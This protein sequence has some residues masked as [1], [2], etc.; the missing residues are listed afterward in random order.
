ML[1][2]Y[3]A[4]L[5]WREHVHDVLDQ[6][7]Y[8][9][10]LHTI[11][12]S[13]IVGLIALNIV[14]LVIETVEPIGRS[15]SQPFRWIEVASVGIFSV[16]YLLRLWCCTL[17][18]EYAKPVRGRLRY[19]ATPMAVIDLLAVLPF[20]L[21]F[22]GADLRHW[23]VLRLFRIFRIA[24]LSRYSESLRTF[25]R[26]LVAKKEDLISSLLVAS[27]LF[28]LAASTLYAVENEA[29]PERFASIPDAMWWAIATLSTVG[30][31]D[32]FPV[33]PLGKLMAG[34]IAILSVG[35]FALPTG[36]LGAAFVEEMS[37]KKQATLV[38][39][40]CGCSLAASGVEKPRTTEAAARMVVWA[41]DEPMADFLVL[42]LVGGCSGYGLEY[43]WAGG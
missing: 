4:S 7:Q 20:Y 39:P 25:G 26:V 5:T 6:G 13:S 37:K 36:I 11:V 3:H 34:I 32:T 19:A 22:V 12:D 23:R 41:P 31:G 16:E 28:L 1:S 27:V 9:G 10:W 40:H 8:H 35:V 43:R 33:T 21:P 29:Q 15:F 14:A 17:R 42:R 24:K 2:S 30:Y 18:A 38:C